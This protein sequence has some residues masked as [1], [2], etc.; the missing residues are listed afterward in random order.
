[1]KREQAHDGMRVVFGRD[2][3]EKTKGVIVR[4]NL[5]KAKVRITEDRGARS[6]AGEEWG[7]PYALM[8]P[9]PDDFGTRCRLAAEA[10]PVRDLAQ[11]LIDEGMTEAELQEALKGQPTI[12]E[13]F[14]VELHNKMRDLRLG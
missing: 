7:V 11:E 14:K 1:M 9:D 13:P 5:K 3:G 12:P 6:K 2:R 8:Q 4:C 10:D